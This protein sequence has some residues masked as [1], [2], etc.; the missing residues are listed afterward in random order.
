MIE[1]LKGEGLKIVDA[2]SEIKN[3]GE[4]VERIM[5]RMRGIDNVLNSLNSIRAHM[6]S[7]YRN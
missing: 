1:N 4:I 6:E 7:S 2:A 3:G 5:Q